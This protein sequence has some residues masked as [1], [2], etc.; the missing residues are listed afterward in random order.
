[1]SGASGGLWVANYVVSQ[2]FPM[3]NGNAWLVETMH[4]AFPFW[5]YGFFCA[6]TVWF[7]WRFVPETKGNSLEEIEKYWG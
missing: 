2:T 7:V 1:M 3:M 6:V 5:L 4:H